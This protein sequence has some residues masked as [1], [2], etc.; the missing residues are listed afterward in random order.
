MTT[1][2]ISKQTQ[3]NWWIN[4]S[5]LGSAIVAAL[6]GI[7]FLFLPVGGF[8]GGR[9]PYYNIQILFDRHTWEDWH[10][11]G[12]VAMIAAALVHLA[13]HW[14]WIASMTRRAWKELSGQCGCINARGR[15]NLAL[16]LVAAIS[17]LLTAISGVYFLFVPGGRWASD[18]MI[19][20]SRAAWDLIHTWAG[21]ILISAAI[22]HFAIHWKWATKVTRSMLGSLAVARTTQTNQTATIPQ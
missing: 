20:F 9:N 17:F 13:L 6:S 19:L 21:V 5:L 18:P 4:A 16:N 8:Q 12:G 11:W 14:P 3:R 2:P 15:W 1:Q 7:Y 22:T 10:T